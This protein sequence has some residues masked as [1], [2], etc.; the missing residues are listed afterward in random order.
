MDGIFFSF[1][2]TIFHSYIVYFAIMCNDLL[3]MIAKS[4]VLISL[5]CTLASIDLDLQHLDKNLLKSTHE[6]NFCN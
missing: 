3:K 6:Y 1:I 5:T 4:L 2:L